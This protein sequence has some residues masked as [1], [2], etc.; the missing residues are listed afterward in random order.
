M[1][2]QDF[3]D[4]LKRVDIS[5]TGYEDSA[6]DDFEEAQEMCTIYGEEY[7]EEER[8]YTEEYY[9]DLLEDF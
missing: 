5:A 1:E 2:N 4:V 3:Y 7:Y 9:E 6:Y 8:E